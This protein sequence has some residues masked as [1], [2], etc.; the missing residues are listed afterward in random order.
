[1]REG[2]PLLKDVSGLDLP[3]FLNLLGKNVLIWPIFLTKCREGTIPLYR[4]KSF[5]MT[6]GEVCPRFYFARA[7]L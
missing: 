2:H 3:V 6:D 1:M 5:L 4:K 7:A